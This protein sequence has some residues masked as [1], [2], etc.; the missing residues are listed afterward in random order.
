MREAD[1]GKETALMINAAYPTRKKPISKRA[2][3]Y[4]RGLERRGQI[5][6]DIIPKERQWLIREINHSDNGYFSGD[7][8]PCRTLGRN[9]L[10]R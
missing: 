5:I 7:V 4:V 9:H 2:N 10:G 6:Q 1:T 3:A 8:R